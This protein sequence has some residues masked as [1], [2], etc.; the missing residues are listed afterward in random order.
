MF[1]G[2]SAKPQPSTGAY[3]G[4]I[5]VG[6]GNPILGDD[7]IGWRV[8]EVVAA[9][10]PEVEVDFLALGGLSL[11]ERLIGYRRVIIIDA[12]QTRDGQCGDVYILP[13]DALPNLSAGHTTAVHDT[14]LATALHLGRSM[15]A[16]VPVDVTIVGI[17]AERIYDFS[18]EISAPVSAAIPAAAQ[19]VLS[20]LGATPPE[21]L[22]P[23]T[24]EKV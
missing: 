11:M 22:V 18:D 3:A 19:A 4:T 10:A 20:L 5:V 2:S 14:S 6:L 1:Y 17:E 13:L 21:S 12:L 8:A 23:S 9:L 24:I 15:G 16:D 7:G